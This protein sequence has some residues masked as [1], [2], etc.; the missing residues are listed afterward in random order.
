M[1][2]YSWLYSE[3][4]EHRLEFWRGKAKSYRRQRDQARRERDVATAHAI[5]TG[6]INHDLQRKINAKSRKRNQAG[7]TLKLG[8]TCLTVP[9]GHEA[10]RLQEEAQAAK[11]LKAEQAKH[12]KSGC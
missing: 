7:R 2:D 3:D 11:R 5:L 8:G 4:L 9:E 6:R 1:A 10:A 12:K